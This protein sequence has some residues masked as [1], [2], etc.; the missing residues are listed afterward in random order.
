MQFSPN[1]P[2][3]EMSDL[4][5]Y[6]IESVGCDLRVSLAGKLKS[7]LHKMKSMKFKRAY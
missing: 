7:T 6:T 2:D 3:L 5:S 1:Q 4:A